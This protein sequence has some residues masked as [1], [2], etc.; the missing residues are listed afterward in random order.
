MAK[1]ERF[2]DLEIWQLAREICNK[3]HQIFETTSLGNNYAL[4]N[5]MDKSSG[6]IMDNI[7]EGFERNGNREFIQFLSIA[8]ASCGELRS[9][10][11]RVLD[12]NHIDED[13]FELLAEMVLLESKKISA[14]INYLSR[15]EYKGS[16][17]NKQQP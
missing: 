13:S 9:Q 14:F 4:R 15:S 12:R 2:E 16:K 1:V 17:F 8:K 6:S 11:Y 5:Q 7:S 10:L 3:V